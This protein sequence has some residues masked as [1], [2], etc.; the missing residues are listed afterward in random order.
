VIILRELETYFA[1][2]IV[3]AYQVRIHK[4]LGAPPAA[5]WRA[6]IDEVAVR[7]P[8]D[9]RRFLI[10]FLPAERRVLQRDGLHLHHIRY[11]SDD[12][13]WHMGRGPE[14]FTVKYDPRD[15]S[16][17][18]VRV[19][20]GYLEA[21]PAD[22]TRPSIALWEQRAALR[23]LREAGRRAV[24]E[25]L[26][27]STILAQRA[28]VDEAVRTTKA[29]RR[30]VPDRRCRRQSRSRRPPSRAR[31]TRRSCCPISRWRNGMTEDFEHLF[32][33]SRPIAALSSEERLRRIRADRW[34][35]YPRAQQALAALEDLISFPRRARMPNLLIVG[36]S[37]MGKTMIVEKFARDH[38]AY[39]DAVNG[40]KRMPVVLVQMV[41]GPDE[42]RFYKRLL[43]AISAPEPSRPTL[44]ALENVALRVLE[45]AQPGMLV[46]DE[47]HSLRAGTVR[48]QARFLNMLRYLGNELRI[49]LVCVGTQQARNSLRTDEQLVRR[50]EAIALPPWRNDQDFAAL[51][52]SL[53]R[54]LPLRRQSEIGERALKSILETTGGVTAA[55]FSLMTR[56]AVAAIVSGEERIMGSDFEDAKTTSLLGEAV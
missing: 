6:R 47:A 42:A 43:A 19:G 26:I 50:F 5:V 41:S 38:P 17:V 55:I 7:M 45:Q 27:F 16:V 21:R 32:A 35:N 12:L 24:D 52:G 54:T 48:E 23:A 9:V 51:I 25:E 44:G 4:A 36:E 11:W 8:N 46:I 30:G 53:Q 14:K 15:L 39:F 13:R 3:G 37:G 2:E 20:E 29:M 40:L 28:L 18:F 49:P 33:G 10:D 34:I 56:L 31:R 1:L 22:R